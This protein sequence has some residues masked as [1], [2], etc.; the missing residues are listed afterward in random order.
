LTV[1]SE[2]KRGPSPINKTDGNHAQKICYK[3]DVNEARN[4][5]ETI[6][7]QKWLTE[8]FYVRAFHPKS[9]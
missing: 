9:R 1:L 3:D 8:S 4:D 7:A 6:K 2:R 5:K